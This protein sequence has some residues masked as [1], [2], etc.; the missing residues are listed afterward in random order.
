MERYFFPQPGWIIDA[1]NE[2]IVPLKGHKP[3]T[4]QSD[5][6]TLELNS[7]GI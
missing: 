6:K 1:I 2:K 5:Q 7:R 4:D 3:G